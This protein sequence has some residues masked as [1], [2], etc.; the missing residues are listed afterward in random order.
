MV[1]AAKGLV[2]AAATR[3]LLEVWLVEAFVAA[4][5]ALGMAVLPRV[6]QAVAQEMMEE[7]VVQGMVAVVVVP[8]Y[9]LRNLVLLVY[10]VAVAVVPR[11]VPRSSAAV[12]A[13]KQCVLYRLVMMVLFVVVNR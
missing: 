5:A 12:A 11:Y 2:G 9:V 1:A 3:E 13:V 10:S 8:R 6:E 7:V 4:I